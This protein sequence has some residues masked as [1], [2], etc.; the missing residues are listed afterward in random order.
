MKTG[1]RIILGGYPENRRKAGPG[2][3]PTSLH[4]D[5]V[6]FLSWVDNAGAE[7]MS[8][9]LGSE[10]WY[11]PQGESLEPQPK[12]SG[13]SGGPCFRLLSEPPYLELVGFIYEGQVPYEVVKVR[14][15]S[16]IAADGTILPGP[17]I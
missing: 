10:N 9:R 4:T 3:H 16:L 15:A 12:L 14:Q 6:T 17:V 7:S 8:I 11:W 2:P 13:G 1:E 5:L